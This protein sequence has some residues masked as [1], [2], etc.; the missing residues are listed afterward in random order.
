M[1]SKQHLIHNYSMLAKSSRRR[2]RCGGLRKSH[3]AARGAYQSVDLFELCG[4]LLRNW[5]TESGSR[6]HCQCHA[7][8]RTSVDA[9]RSNQITM[10]YVNADLVTQFSFHVHF[11]LVYEGVANDATTAGIGIRK[12]SHIPYGHFR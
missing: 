8:D 1:Y 3:I 5:S 11:F 6:S 2:K 4:F 9:K 7:N 10:Q 12:A